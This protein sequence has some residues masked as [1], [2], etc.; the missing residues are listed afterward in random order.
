MTREG[1]KHSGEDNAFEYANGGPMP[2]DR[3]SR[4]HQIIL[5][6]T[7]MTTCGLMAGCPQLFSKPAPTTPAPPAPP[8]CP[9]DSSAELRALREENAALHQKLSAGEKALAD[10]RTEAQELKKTISSLNL[11]LLDLESTAHELQRRT[12]SQQQRLEAAIVEVVRAKAKLRSIESKAEA[13]STLAEAE[14]AVRDLKGRLSGLDKLAIE[15]VETAEQLLSMSADAFKDQNFG[16]ALYLANQSKARVRAI[17][18]QL[19]K[20]PEGAGVS[21]ETPFSYPLTL[22]VIKKSNVRQHPGLTEKIIALLDSGS[23]VTGYGYKDNWV[24]IETQEGIKGWIFQTL[25]AAP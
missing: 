17:Q 5:I 9:P 16:G 2:F 25:I 24:H 22:K 20:I 18:T 13:V 15:E 7:L 10:S 23:L 21:G 12:E 8:P 4:I 11:R 3:K 14:I 6:A 19:N 1:F